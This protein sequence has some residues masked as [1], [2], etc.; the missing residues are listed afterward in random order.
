[1]KC[2]EKVPVSASNGLQG[3]LKAG[4]KS[5]GHAILNGMSDPPLSSSALQKASGMANEYQCM[6]EEKH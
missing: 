5:A 6:K 1:M 3:P 2:L 4:L